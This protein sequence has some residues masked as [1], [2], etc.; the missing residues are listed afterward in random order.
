MNENIFNKKGYNT[1]SLLIV[2]GAVLVLS[3]LLLLAFNIGWL[4]PALKSIFFS[5]PMLFVLFAVI[6][7]VKRQRLISVIFLLLGLFFL[8]PR[9]ETV[10]PGILGEAGKEF[11]SNYWPLLLIVIGL[12][13]IIA[14]AINRKKKVPFRNDI[15]NKQSNTDGWI[16]KDV[17]FGGS[18]SVFLEPIFKGGKIDVVFG[19]VVLDLRKTTLPETTVYLNIDVVFGGVTIYIPENW[20]VKSDIDSVFGGYSDKRVN[21][22]VSDDKSDSKLVLQGTLIFSGCTVQ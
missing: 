21:V 17:I 12:M 8:L 4:N 1:L 13:I 22:V 19:G 3:G 5:W 9:L 11:T 18:E 16:V 6:G 20:S 2:L 15:V 10:Y 14:V 7:F